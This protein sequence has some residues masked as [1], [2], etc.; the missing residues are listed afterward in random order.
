MQGMNKK[1]LLVAI[2]LAFITTFLGYRYISTINKSSNSQSEN[3]KVI[4][5]TVDIPPRTQINAEMI[6]EISIPKDSYLIDSLQNMD[7]IL[8][9][10]TKE[11]ILEGEIIPSERLIEEK[12]KELSIRLPNGKRAV[13][14]FADK[15]IGVSD[16]IEPGDYVDIFV[17]L[18]EKTVDNKITTTIY[19]QITRSFLQN[20]EVLAISK[21]MN[22]TDKIKGETPDSYTVTLAVTVEDGE[23][24]ILAEDMGRI[25][26]GLR[27]IDDD[28]V[29]DTPGAIREDLASEKGKLVLPK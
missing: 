26:L 15:I 10:Y 21:E 9:M 6:R 8:G 3:K 20:V 12:D 4:V 13:S 14:V 16:L 19:P 17:T 27:P 25:R 28:K 1:I 24:L 11:S 29:Y 2:V 5:A 23:K 18:D 7:E 22:R